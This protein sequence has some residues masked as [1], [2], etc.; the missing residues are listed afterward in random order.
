MSDRILLSHGSG[1]QMT[2]EL[3]EEIIVQAFSNSTLNQLSDAAVLTIGDG[4]L[5]MT[6][7][8]F[9]ITPPIFPGGNIGELSIYGTV[10]DLVML[11][12]K[13][14]YLSSALILEEGLDLEL[15]KGIINS[16][17]EAV[18]ELGV[19]IVTG[20]TKVVEKGKG[21]QIFINTTGIGIIPEGIELSPIKIR[22]GDKVILSGTMG[23]HGIT[24]MACRERLD[25]QM[26]LKS[27]CQPLHRLA[28]KMLEVEPRIRV[29]RDPTR[30]G[31][32][33]VLN[34]LAKQARVEIKV[35]E[36]DVPILPQVQGFCDLLGLD[37][38]HV[39]N[40]GKLLA[41][42]PCE[43]ADRILTAM[44][45]LP[46]GKDAAIIGE[47]MV[48]TEYPEV[49]VETEIG[50]TRILESLTGDQLPRIC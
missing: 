39:A 47:V 44:Q 20:D 48:Q 24:I 41:I 15:L 34:E 16:M 36:T 31:V 9:V 4:R 17:A 7:D 26:D 38:F 30:G 27:D 18:N 6:T 1:G 45:R 13:P 12:A 22:K 42:V 46:E 2:R 40:E 29:M 11:G 49:Y 23:D 50:T 3:I 43:S 8:S 35:K 25:F 33:S 28:H 10:N 37:P 14:L 21:D 32:A 19:E 5:A